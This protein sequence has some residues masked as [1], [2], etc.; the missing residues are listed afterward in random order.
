MSIFTV[1]RAGSEDPTIK[2]ILAKYAARSRRIKLQTMDP[3]RNPGWMRQYDPSGQ[4]IGPGSLVVVD[5]KKFKT[6]GL[7]DM[8]NYDTSN[9]E[10][11]SPSSPHC[12]WSRG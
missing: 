1:A 3:D 2:E 11:A 6:I 12:R 8:Y 9:S 5:G 7:Y 4:G 10:P